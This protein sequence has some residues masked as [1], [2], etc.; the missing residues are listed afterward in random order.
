MSLFTSNS[1][2]YCALLVL[3]LSA[4]GEA[5]T[6]DLQ[7]CDTSADLATARQSVIYG[8]ATWIS[9]EAATEVLSA[10]EVAAVASE[11][12]ILRRRN[13]S[14]TGG[15]PL[16][17]SSLLCDG[18]PLAEDVALAGCSGV[19]VAPDL[20]VTAKHCTEIVPCE[21]MF[22]TTEF[23]VALRSDDEWDFEGRRCVGELA[24]DEMLDTALIKLAPT[25][26]PTIEVATLRSDEVT[27][28]TQVILVSHPLGTSTKVDLDAH[29]R[30]SAAGPGQIWLRGDAFKGSS[31][32]GVFD[33]QGRLV[34][35][36]TAGL[37]D[38][39]YD[40]DAECI[41]LVRSDSEGFE[42]LATVDSVL[43]DACDIALDHPLCSEITDSPALEPDLPEQMGCK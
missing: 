1:N 21:E 30:P 40:Q 22:V 18:E 25:T 23:D 9:P 16:T 17:E 33:T 43:R 8:E 20:M 15:A 35:I 38:F 14:G 39:N 5:T 28:D 12:A 4:C 32:G 19:L 34:G 24:S 42:R 6:P 2:T 7:V 13:R 29:V 36:V 3:V 27:S 31:G 10:P 26:D 37:S 11:V 41:R